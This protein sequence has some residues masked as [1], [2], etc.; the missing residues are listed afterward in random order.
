ML[1]AARDNGGFSAT[2]VSQPV[3][4]S[5]VGSSKGNLKGYLLPMMIRTLN[6]IEN[7]A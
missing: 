6:L 3:T 7:Q 5:G 4:N 2:Q 1:E